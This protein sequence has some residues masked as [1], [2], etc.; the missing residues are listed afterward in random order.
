MM[1]G[2]KDFEGKNVYIET[3]SNRKYS[4]KVIKI[5]IQEPLIW[6]SIID[7]FGDKIVFVHSEIVLIQEE[8]T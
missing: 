8:K 1:E 7:K 6:I 5:D 2:W 4:G 3:K